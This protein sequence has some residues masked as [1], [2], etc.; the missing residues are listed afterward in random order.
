MHEEEYEEFKRVKHNYK[1]CKILLVIL[2]IGFLLIGATTMYVEKRFRSEMDKCN[3]LARNH[4]KCLSN[5]I[6]TDKPTNMFY[7]KGEIDDK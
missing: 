6:I 3:E 2:I 5:Q 4:T 1:T 7:I